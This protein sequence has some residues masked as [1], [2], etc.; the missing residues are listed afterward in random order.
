MK[1]NLLALAVGAAIVLPGVA[2]ADAATVYGRMDMSLDFVSADIDDDTATEDSGSN[3]AVTSNASRFGVKGDAELG[4]GLTA[5]YK[6]EWQVSGDSGSGSTTD[7]TTRNRYVGLM[8]GFGTVKLGGMDTPLKASQG[9][10][11]LFDNHAA[12]I[13]SI[14]EGENREGNLI[15]YSS[16]KIADMLSLNVAFQPGEENEAGGSCSGGDVND[17]EDCSDGLT[18][19]ISASAVLNTGAFYGALAVD[20]N[21]DSRDT[22]RAVGV[23]T[24]GKIQLGGLL[25]TSEMNDDRIVTNAAEPKETTIAANGAVKIGKTKLKGQIGLRTIDHDVDDVDDSKQ[26]LIA[27]GAEHH[28]TKQTQV[29]AEYTNFSVKDNGSTTPQNDPSIAQLAVG[30]QHKF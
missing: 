25:Q 9:K 28:F 5:I 1:R 15:Q 27:F 20:S 24:I 4:H 30:I 19:G 14:S 22:L 6:M 7:L 8:G 11:D 18:D 17:S 23:L 13:A 16:P 29:Y 12:D 3:W 2:L 26:T 10:F 21:I